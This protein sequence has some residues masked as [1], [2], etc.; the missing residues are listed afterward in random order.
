MLDIKF[1]KGSS[2]VFFV[3]ANFDPKNDPKIVGLGYF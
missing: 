1:G 2:V 3:C